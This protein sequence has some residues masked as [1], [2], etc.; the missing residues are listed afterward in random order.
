MLLVVRYLVTDSFLVA[1]VLSLV[2]KGETVFYPCYQ[3]LLKTPCSQI[4]LNNWKKT[5]QRIK[6][7]KLATEVAKCIARFIQASRV[8]F[9]WD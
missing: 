6:L 3:R 7:E 8:C 5:P 4:R 9:S 1:W 2:S